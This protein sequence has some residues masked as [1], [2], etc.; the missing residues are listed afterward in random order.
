MKRIIVFSLFL[1]CSSLCFSYE[2]ISDRRK[3]QNPTQPAH[4]IVPLPYSKP[5]IGEGV[6]VMATVSNIAETTADI[7]GM[8]VGGDA[9]GNIINGS[10][11]P[12]YSDILFLNFYWQDINRAAINN[13]SVRGIN[14]TQKDDFTV[15]DIS[16]ANELTAELNL[17]FYERRL[18]L[19]YLHTDFEYQVDA[20]R[21]YNGAL[22]T[23]LGEPFRNSGSSD[24][25]RI[26]VDLTDDYLDPRKGFRVDMAYQNHNANSVNEPDFYTLDYNLLGYIPVGRLDT[27]ALNYYQSDAHVKRQGNTDSSSIRTEINANCALT[28][29]TCL[30][31]E[32]ELV[33]NFI[34]AR[35]NGTAATLGG[36]MRMRSFPQGRY[37]GAHM[38]FIGAEYRWNITQEAT[39]FNYFIWKDVR[40]GIQIAFFAELGTVSET[41]SQLWDESRYSVGTGFRL[42]A[43]SGAVYRAD[44]ATGNEGVEVVVI[45]DY[46]WE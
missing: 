15:L 46:P 44:V 8:F 41:G 13:Y 42:V 37:Q 24:R 30:T 23:R 34:N 12:L 21:D 1:A 9:R 6:I 27:L 5:G 16:V 22:I 29:T 40:T 18:N 26:S 4:L 25:Y 33:N 36:D 17:A 31:T 7:T 10:E 20:I 11:I 19:Y 35:T 38:A 2:L 28:D 43:G 32:E 14:N 45:F 39:P 3:D